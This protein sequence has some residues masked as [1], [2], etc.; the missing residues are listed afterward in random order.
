MKAPIIVNKKLTPLTKIAIWIVSVITLFIMVISSVLI[1]LLQ[2]DWCA[3]AVGNAKYVNGRPETAITGCIDLLKLQVGALATQGW[4]SNVG[5]VSVLF[6]L[7]VI[8]IARG[9][10]N[11]DAS[12]TGLKVNV[13]GNEAVDI[14]ADYVKDAAAD[15]AEEV[16]NH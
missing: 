3:I 5:L 11:V 14:A 15:A 10:A 2:S 13:S 16:K 9:K 1:Y 8:V 7:M 4:I 6:I 12:A